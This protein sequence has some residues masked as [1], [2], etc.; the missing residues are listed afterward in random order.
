MKMGKT[1][2]IKDSKRILVTGCPLGEATDKI[3]NTIRRK[4][5]RSGSL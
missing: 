5:R 2:V 4:W 3:I 1:N